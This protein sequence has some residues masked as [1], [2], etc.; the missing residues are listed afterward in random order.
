MSK[1]VWEPEEIEALRRLYPD[2]QVSPE[3]MEAFFNRNYRAIS[4]KACH[5]GLKRS[6]GGMRAWREEEI[7]DLKQ[8]YPGL[9]YTKKQLE[10]HFGRSWTAIRIRGDKLGLRR[11]RA[12]SW[13]EDEIADLRRMYLDLTVAP[14]Q[15]VAHFGRSLKAIRT[16]AS[17]LGLKRYNSQVNHA[18]FRE[19][20]THEQAYW[21]GFL[22]ADGCVHITRQG[23]YNIR[24]DLHVRDEQA[25]R[26]FGSSIAPGATPHRYNNQLRIAFNSKEMAQDLA[27]YGIVPNKSL[28]LRWPDILPDLYTPTF[29]L[30]YFDGDGCLSQSKR[31]NKRYWHWSVVGT[32]AF[33]SKIHQYIQDHSQVRLSEP[34]RVDKDGSSQLYVLQSAHQEYI[35]QIDAMLNISGLGLPRKHFAQFTEQ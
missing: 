15:L 28:I 19:I 23:A 24:L 2:S 20:N 1:P 11:L 18:Y 7:A 5:L 16:E 34:G 21:L 14:E 3:Q 35:R 31:G 9:R 4:L 25:I 22:A 10:E 26:K 6:T 29:I 32:Q 13:T 8:M 27:R 30:G 12:N 17:E 33:L